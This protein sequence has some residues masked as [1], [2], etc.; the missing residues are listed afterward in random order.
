[1]GGY[2]LDFSG[3]GFAEGTS[4]A[5]MIIFGF[6][7]EQNSVGTLDYAKYFA[8]CKPKY[9]EYTEVKAKPGADIVN[10]L[11][12][13]YAGLL[14]ACTIL[15]TF[16]SQLPCFKPCCPAPA[17]NKAQGDTK[18]EAK[19]QKISSSQLNSEV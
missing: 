19:Q 18:I 17:P 16:A 1:M 13:A 8:S 5:T 2:L 12:G 3:S 4:I 10:D 11:L 14:S 15:V 7:P 9:C 6:I